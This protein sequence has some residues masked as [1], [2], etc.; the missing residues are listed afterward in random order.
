MGEETKMI[1]SVG[2]KLGFGSVLVVLGGV[3]IVM[4]PLLGWTDFGKPWDFMLGFV[5]GVC[6]GLGVGLAILGLIE[7]R[8][9]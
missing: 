1:L 6:A 9:V 7:R 2:Q 3:G 5:I 4:A 8:S